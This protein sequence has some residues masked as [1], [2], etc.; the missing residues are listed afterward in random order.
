M[1]NNP[2][3]PNGPD[4]D[5][6]N[7]AT[8]SN[9]DT[10]NPDG[11][12]P[13]DS[14]FFDDV[15]SFFDGLFSEP[16]RTDDNFDP[17]GFVDPLE[18]GT[19]SGWL[20]DSTG[21]TNAD[22]ADNFYDALGW[23]DRSVPPPSVLGYTPT[24]ALAGLYG[25]FDSTNMMGNLLSNL[26]PGSLGHLVSDLFTK[27]TLTPEGII[28]GFAGPLS[29]LV[30]GVGLFEDALESILGRQLTS[31]EKQPAG[32]PVNE[33]DQSSHG[34]DN[35]NKDTVKY[36]QAQRQETDKTTTPNQEFEDLLDSI[37]NGNDVTNFQYAQMPFFQLLSNDF[38]KLAKRGS[39]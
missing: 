23:P 35:I 25:T 20:T 29:P 27:E 39:K 12:G 21:W 7:P 3:D 17:D 36:K 31:D 19:R 6:S 34:D 30:S 4:T 1:S 14:N 38:G 24:D 16:E 32:T 26:V 5:D 37:I 18:S 33:N 15:A 8:P 2:N 10:T 28:K 22:F 9:D 13:D 11:S